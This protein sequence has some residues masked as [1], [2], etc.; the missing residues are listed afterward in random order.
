VRDAAV[1]SGNG[2]NLAYPLPNSAGGGSTPP[3]SLAG[4]STANLS[5]ATLAFDA[6]ADQISNS[7]WS[8]WRFNY[9]INGGGW[10]A[11]AL[12]AA[13]IALF[14]RAGSYAFSIAV[15]PNELVNG[16]NTVQFSGTGF[17]AGYQPFIGNIDLIVQ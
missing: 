8:A 14:P 17:Y 12:S 5:S 7:N 1:P 11:A 3:L 13:E 4:V 10:H 9:R 16:T 2:L 15:D 6:F